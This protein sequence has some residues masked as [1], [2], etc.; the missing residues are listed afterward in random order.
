MI[1][2]GAAYFDVEGND[3]NWIRILCEY[4][5]LIIIPAGRSHRMSTTSKVNLDFRSLL[6]LNNRILSKSDAFL[7][8]NPIK[9]VQNYRS[10]G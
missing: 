9:E 2:E 3:G 1:I 4:G 6:I 7:K 10:S 8:T 5:D